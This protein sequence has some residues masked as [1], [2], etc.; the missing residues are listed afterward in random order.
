MFQQNRHILISDKVP[1]GREHY[2]SLFSSKKKGDPSFET[3]I[4]PDTLSLSGFFYAQ[5]RQGK[6]I[7]LSLLDIGTDFT[8]GCRTAQALLKTDPETMVILISDMTELSPSQQKSLLPHIYFFRKSAASKSLHSLVSTLLRNWNERFSLREKFLH[9][10]AAKEEIIFD[11]KGVAERMGNNRN[12][13]GMMMKVF[14]TNIPKQLQELK[15]KVKDKNMEEITRMGHTIK[16]SSATAGAI[17]M[18]EI[19]FGIENA[20]KNRNSEEAVRLIGELEAAFEEMKKTAAAK[21][22]I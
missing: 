12:L 15:E 21:G 4:F 7:P 13:I 11:E 9:L 18:Q 22:L 16:G 19:A 14:V 20:G 6:R 10:P 2:E 5:Y 3:D 17:S 8:D 1:E